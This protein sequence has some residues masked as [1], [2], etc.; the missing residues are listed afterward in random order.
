MDA[1]ATQVKRNWINGYDDGQRQRH[2]SNRKSIKFPT[3]GNSNLD[4][5]LPCSV[6]ESASGQSRYILWN[7]SF[8]LGAPRLFINLIAPGLD[9]DMNVRLRTADHGCRRA[10]ALT[11]VYGSTHLQH[12][13][14]E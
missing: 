8:L 5:L 4:K 1:D 3:L 10:V 9:M 13:M 6:G 11:R 12:E 7:Q 14:F 2:A